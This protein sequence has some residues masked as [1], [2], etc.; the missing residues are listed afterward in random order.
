MQ[1][2]GFY[3]YGYRSIEGKTV[4][5]AGKVDLGNATSGPSAVAFSPD[6]K[7]ALVTR[8]NDNR[9][10]VLTIDGG[11]DNWTGKWPPEGLADGDEVPT[12]ARQRTG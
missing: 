4:K 3:W 12:E 2:G 1:R 6:G 8:D 11:L 9:I 5:A 10:S 7:T